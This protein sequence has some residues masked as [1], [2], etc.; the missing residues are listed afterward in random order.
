LQSPNSISDGRTTS[1]IADPRATA[2]EGSV[3]SVRP[4]AGEE[5]PISAQGDLRVDP[6]PAFKEGRTGGPSSMHRFA[7]GAL[8]SA[9]TLLIVALAGLATLVIWDSY[10]AAP[11]TRDGSIRVQ[12]ASIA[13]QVSGQIMEVRV[14]DNQFVRQGDVLYV[15]DPFDFK[16]ALDTS[17]AQ[18]RQKDADLQVKR[19]QAERRMRLSNLATTPEEQQIFAGN[20]TQAQAAFDA[21]QQQV[22]QADIN[23]K[24]TQVRSPVNGYVTNLLMRV[25]DY[26]RV[27][28][29]NISVIDADSYWIDGYFE[30]TKM[31]HVCVGNDAEAVLMGYRNPILGRVESV[32]R[33]ISVPNAAPSTQGLPSVDPVYTWVRL[34]QRVPVRVRITDVPP[35]VPLVS[36]MTVTVTIRDAEA[37]KGGA[38]WLHQRFAYLV[39]RLG[40]VVYGPQTSSDCVPRVGERNGSIVTLPTPK[41]IAPLD[42]AAR[43]LA[44]GIADSPRIRF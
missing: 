40:D 16:V 23:L 32:T 44:P 43:E 34:A 14:V 31:A 15:I 12:V 21:A 18:L 27:G 24:R 7:L 17:Q 4:M 19:I 30:E 9:A 22:A 25:G 35:G 10:V 42:P 8:R 2:A 1:S 36:G 39:N 3:S 41:A 37:R 28:S 26:A 11:W 13:P 29:T 38:G 6:Q 20:A 5:R 33:G